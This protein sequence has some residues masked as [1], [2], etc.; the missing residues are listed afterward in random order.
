MSR[1][2]DSPNG[3]ARRVTVC[4]F[5]STAVAAV[6]ADA[7][8]ATIL[9]KNE[10]ARAARLLSP[11]RARHWAVARALLRC[12]MAACTAARPS[13]VQFEIGANGKPRLASDASRDRF[14]FNLS[15]S[16][17]H[18]VVA[19][20]EHRDI[21][22][23]IEVLDQALNARQVAS[24]ALTAEEREAI[25]RMPETERTRAFYVCWVR[26]EAVIKAHG[27]E[28]AIPL[29]AFGVSV[30]P[31]HPP[32]VEWTTEPSL[33]PNAVW[34]ADLPLGNGIAGAAAIRR[35]IAQEQFELRLR[36]VRLDEFLG[37]I[38]A[39]QPLAITE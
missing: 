36:P 27:A 21:G 34:L 17:P 14:R 32:R 7:A 39:D 6:A 38:R 19:I 18:A 4:L 1:P 24:L 2:I 10:R 26:K 3:E 25:D 20:A 28:L 31:R 15:H 16:G 11:E 13:R 35:L 23:D 12:A 9:D 29:D 30:S 5:D 8:I 37:A 22:V 33:A